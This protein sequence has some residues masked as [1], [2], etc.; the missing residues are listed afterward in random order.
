[1]PL[2]LGRPLEI[3]IAIWEIGLVTV[4]I[5]RVVRAIRKSRAAGPEGKA[6]DAYSRIRAAA[7]TTLPFRRVADAIGYEIAV[8]AYALFGADRKLTL[9]GRAFSYHRKNGY[10]AIVFGLMFAMIAE[11]GGVH[12]L[13]VHFHHPRIALLLT[14]LSLY[15][16]LWFLGDYQAARRRPIRI[17]ADHLAICTELRWN[18]DVPFAAIQKIERPDPLRPFQK[19]RGAIRATLFG[20][21]LFVLHLNEPLVADG[22]YGRQALVERVGF[23][24]D[25]DA[26]FLAA[27]PDGAT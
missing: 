1:M 9:P 25:E 3:L 24:V 17:E 13:L 27:L 16:A 19:G 26:E 4:I 20:A 2:H 21:P 11:T 14:V 8:T 10:G 12:L 18:L 7:R 5:W 6:E 22:P 15:G 23:T